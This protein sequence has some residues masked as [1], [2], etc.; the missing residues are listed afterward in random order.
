MSISKILLPLDGSRLAESIVPAVGSLARQLH[1]SVQLVSVADPIATELPAFIQPEHLRRVAEEANK[2]VASDDLLAERMKL[3]ETYLES[4]AEKLRAAGV[5]QPIVT[6]VFSGEAPEQIVA[7]V[8][9]A[10]AD[11]VA[12]GTHGRSGLRRGLLGSVADRVLRASSVPV[13]LVHP[14]EFVIEHPDLS[15]VESVV[16]GLDGSQLAESSLGLAAEIAA[17]Y[18]AELVLLRATATK[19]A[20]TVAYV[21]ESFL[22]GHDYEQG[23]DHL[24]LRYLD[25]KAEPFVAE[26]LRVRTQVDSRVAL[27]AIQSAATEF[28][29]ALIVLASRGRSGLSRWVLGSVVDAAV[30]TVE[31]PILVVPPT[32]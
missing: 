17:A 32:S 25:R 11:L 5:S 30:R 18:E 26:G 13:L 29:N 9:E 10:R 24:A 15:Q 14:R 20:H 16:V 12:M 6:R 19:A 22:A 2:D 4:V 1:A 23:L 8:K 7:A 31:R 28:P 21:E 3:A 27:D